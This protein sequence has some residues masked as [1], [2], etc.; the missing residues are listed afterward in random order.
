NAGRVCVAV[1]GHPYGPNEERGV[2]RSLDGGKTFEKA[3]YRDQNVGGSDVQIDPS[4]PQIVYAALWESREGPWENGVFNGDGGGIFK[5]IG[6]GK[7]WRQ[8]TKG[9]PPDIVQANLVI[10]PSAPRTLFAAVRTKTI[11]KLYRSDDGGETWNGTTDDPRPGLGIGGGDLPAVRFD[12]KNSQIV[13]S[14]STV[15]WKSTVVGTTRDG[16]R[17]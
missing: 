13:Y 6:G 14:A 5:S 2:Y 11:A 10:A 17:G 15:G 1:V 7:T 3:L 4:N 16:W 12:P 9:M 8:L